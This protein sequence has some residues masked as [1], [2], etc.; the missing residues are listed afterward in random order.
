M[1][2]EKGI[3]RAAGAGRPAVYPF[4]EMEVDDS[5]FF[6]DQNSQGNA[7]KAATAHG[8]AHGKKFSARSVVGGVRIWRM[9]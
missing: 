6:Y 4:A 9:S 2:I 1:E 8:R 5:I 3:K 7:M